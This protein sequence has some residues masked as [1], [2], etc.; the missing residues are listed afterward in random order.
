MESTDTIEDFSKKEKE[1]KIL[2][3]F[4]KNFP[5]EFLLFYYDYMDRFHV[6]PETFDDLFDFIDYSRV[7]S[8]VDKFNASIEKVKQEIKN[9]R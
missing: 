6:K 7:K 3:I 4:N 1:R 8:L 2:E 9:G 5:N